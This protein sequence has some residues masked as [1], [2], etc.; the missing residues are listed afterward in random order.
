MSVFRVFFAG[1]K[2]WICRQA[3]LRALQPDSYI[4]LELKQREHEAR[5]SHPLSRILV[6]LFSSIRRL[7]ETFH[8]GA[9]SL[10]YKYLL[11]Q[12]YFPV[13]RCCT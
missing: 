12:I 11:T 6:H 2:V 5:S 4:C 13:S 3:L 9:F 8:P 10:K 1:A 7:W